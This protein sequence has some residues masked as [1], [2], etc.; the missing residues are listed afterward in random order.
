MCVWIAPQK[1]KEMLLS[2]RNY[3]HPSTVS[4]F[5]RKEWDEKKSPQRTKQKPSTDSFPKLK[6]E[7]KL[8][9]GATL[10]RDPP[11]QG[12]SVLEAFRY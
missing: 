9:R 8:R 12:K 2:I 10:C 4:N 1:L 5:D 11:Q 6:N 3:L 7:R